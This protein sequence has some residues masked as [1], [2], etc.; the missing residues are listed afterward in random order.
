MTLS[1]YDPE[2]FIDDGSPV[3]E[4][5]HTTLQSDCECCM[6]YYREMQ[7]PDIEEAD[8]EFVPYSDRDE[9]LEYFSLLE[10][11]GLEDGDLNFEEDFAELP[12]HPYRL[13]LPFRLLE[14][15]VQG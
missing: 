12:G 14:K 2:S 15:M 7:D 11:L 5:D 10:Y 13:F 8:F 3:E 9:V 1:L 6:W 4:C